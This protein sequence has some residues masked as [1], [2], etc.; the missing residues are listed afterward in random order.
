M[1]AG[2]AIATRAIALPRWRLVAGS[3]SIT[4]AVA[5]GGS[6]AGG[7]TKVAAVSAASAGGGSAMAPLAKVASVSVAA[8]GGGSASAGLVKVAAVSVSSAGGGAAFAGFT[9]AR[10]DLFAVDV[11]AGRVTTAPAVQTITITPVRG[12]S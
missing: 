4:V 11:P 9:A 10:G 8:S 3:V 1:I 12:I 2:A 7:L 5:G 6:V